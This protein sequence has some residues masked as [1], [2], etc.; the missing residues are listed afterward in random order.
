MCGQ[1][2][3]AS[4]Y[5]FASVLRFAPH[6]ANA[7]PSHASRIKLK[8][9]HKSFS[10]KLSTKQTFLNRKTD[11]ENYQ[12]CIYGYI[13]IF[14]RRFSAIVQLLWNDFVK[15]MATLLSSAAIVFSKLTYSLPKG[16]ISLLC[17]TALHLHFELL[18]NNFKFSPPI[19]FTPL[20]GIIIRNRSRTTVT[21]CF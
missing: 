18:R 21:Y 13:F 9:P 2:R 7:H 5:A 19:L 4:G 16:F 12:I 11:I 14:L 17:Q 6:W 20:F 15:I 1:G 10:K 3:R 8:T